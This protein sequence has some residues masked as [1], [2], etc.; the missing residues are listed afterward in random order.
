[1]KSSSSGSAGSAS[2]SLMG[3][4]SARRKIGVAGGRAAA[5]WLP[6]CSTR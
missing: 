4:G 6:R 2:S 1:M 5:R 3:R